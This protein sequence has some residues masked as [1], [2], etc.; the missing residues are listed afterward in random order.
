[1]SERATKAVEQTTTKVKNSFDAIVKTFER[2]GGELSPNAVTAVFQ[3]LQGEL[4]AAHQRSINAVAMKNALSGGSGFSLSTA[5]PAATP[6]P[7]PLP[8]LAMPAPSIQ[9]T[10]D[11]QD[12]LELE[13]ALAREEA[14][15]EPPPPEK[16]K[17][18]IGRLVGTKEVVFGEPEQVK[19]VKPEPG[20]VPDGRGFIK[21]VG[22][23]SDFE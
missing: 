5:R 11:D 21:D 17:K 1:M 7:Q 10:L 6:L 13:R 20:E 4:A 16:P 19:P 9:T 8:R 3:Y 22:F 15:A 23:I 18:P 2:F 14:Y 12:D